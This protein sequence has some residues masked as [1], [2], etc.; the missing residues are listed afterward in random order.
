MSSQEAPNCFG[1][2]GHLLRQY[3]QLQWDLGVE[4]VRNLLHQW[5][6]LEATM[7]GASTVLTGPLS[8]QLKLCRVS[9]RWTVKHR[10]PAS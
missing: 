7:A 4:Q 6:A 2:R 8:L 9:P 5:S 3:V 10:Q 1:Q